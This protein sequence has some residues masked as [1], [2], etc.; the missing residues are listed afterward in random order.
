M[1][2]FV[3]SHSKLV[4]VGVLLFCATVHSLAEENMIP[5]QVQDWQVA[6][7]GLEK[8]GDVRGALAEYEKIIQA[9]PNTPYGLDAC[10]KAAGLF[11]K[12]K[13]FENLR[14]V[15]VQICTDFRDQAGVFRVL[16]KL[17]EDCMYAKAYPSAESL[18]AEALTQLASK[19]RVILATGWLGMVY[20]HQG[21]FNGAA[22]MRDALPQK[23]DVVASDFL[24]AMSSIGWGYYCADRWDEALTTYRQALARDP[25]HTGAVHLQYRVVQTRIAQGN[26]DAADRE[27]ETLLTQYVHRNNTPGLAFRLANMYYDKGQYPK[28][29]AVYETLLARFADNELAPSIQGMEIKTYT[30]MGKQYRRKGQPEL[31]IAAY[32]AVLERFPDAEQIPSIRDAIVETWADVGELA[33]AH[34]AVQTDIENCPHRRELL[35]MI[36]RVAVESARAGDTDTAMTLV[37]EIFDQNPE[38]ADQLF[39]Y[40]TLARV[41]VHQHKDA[42]A[43]ATVN[44][45]LELFKEDPNALAYHLFGVGEEYYYLA[46]KAMESGDLESVAFGCQKAVEMWQKPIISSNPKVTRLMAFCYQQLGQT[47]QATVFYNKA[48]RANPDARTSEGAPPLLA[49]DRYCGAYAVWH[50]LRHYGTSE[51]VTYLANQMGIPSQGYATIS[52]IVEVLAIYELPAQAVRIQPDKA[53]QIKTPFIQYLIPRSDNTLGHFV[54]CIPAESGKAIVLDGTKDP[55]LIDMTQYQD[56]EAYWDGTIIL[57]GQSRESYVGQIVS[58]QLL[59]KT[60]LAAAYCWL[61]DESPECLRKTEEF[62]AYMLDQK[63]RDIRGGCSDLDCLPAG[64]NCYVRKTCV[65][66]SDCYGLIWACDDVT[67]EETCQPNPPGWRPCYYDPAHNCGPKQQVAPYCPGTRC[68]LDL[69]ILNPSCVTMGKDWI[70]QCYDGWW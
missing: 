45:A 29:I 21:N 31:A 59:W 62:Y 12:Q 50:L 27:M 65:V 10:A 40:T 56:T 4:S 39:G 18:C 51:S 67:E 69:R 63:L 2:S 16:S 19:P 46:Q 53:V 42:E 66:D 43:A 30:M 48:Q 70:H 36:T 25:D 32:E 41:Y 44:E 35:R 14:P 5:Q 20:A 17:V 37:D 33:K 24:D 23:T 15:V 57:I 68:A 34:Q 61:E 6:A 26:A 1:R 60:A 22:L 52:D 11:V 58:R 13:Q 9:Y 49:G 8:S 64:K 54:L 28:A 47:E 7:A 55:Y 3:V 38:G